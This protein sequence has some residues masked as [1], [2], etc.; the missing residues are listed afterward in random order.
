M[1]DSALAALL[2]EHE[3]ALLDPALSGSPEALCTYRVTAERHSSLR[4]SV[5]VHE[6]SRWKLRFHQGTR[7]PA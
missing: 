4:S 1:D 3:R 2:E 6:D 7:T 5:W